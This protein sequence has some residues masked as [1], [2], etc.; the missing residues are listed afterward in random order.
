MLVFFLTQD[1]VVSINVNNLDIRR[2]QRKPRECFPLWLLVGVDET[3][4]TFSLS[5]KSTVNFLCVCVCV[6][7][8]G[9]FVYNKKVGLSFTFWRRHQLQLLVWKVWLFLYL[10]W[11]QSLIYRFSMPTDCQDDRCWHDNCVQIILFYCLDTWD[12]HI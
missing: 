10:Y 6:C 5:W 9:V 11:L 2:N 3:W 1:N 12:S 4:P 8:L 7:V